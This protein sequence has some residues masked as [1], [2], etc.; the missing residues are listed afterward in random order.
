MS[1]KQSA[2]DFTPAIAHYTVYGMWTS[3]NCYK[4]RLAL[5]QLELSYAWVEINSANGETRTPE[6]LAKNAN[7]KVPL[8]ETASGQ[9]LAESNAILAYLAE[10]SRLWP[11]D[12]WQ[13][14]QTLKWMFFEQHGHERYVAEARFIMKY[15]PVD[16]P[17]RQELPQLRDRGYQALG[18]MEKHLQQQMFFSG[19]GYGVADISLFAYTH[20]A[21]EGGFD[22][23]AYP[24]LHDWF[25]RVRAQPGFIAL[26]SRATR[27]QIRT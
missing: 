18:V 11:G 26:S 5:E 3:G 13:R 15:L 9:F 19:S 8:L 2:T 21:E 27:F 22:L 7:G 1:D 14:A 25:E 12:H 24:V 20:C 16:H 17:R 23:S 10:G 4:V 6:F